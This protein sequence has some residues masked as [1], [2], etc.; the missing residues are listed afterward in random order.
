MTSTTPITTGTM[1]AASPHTTAAPALGP[2]RPVAWPKRTSV[3]LANGLEVVLAESHTFPKITAQ[4]FIRSGNA[5][6]AHRAPGVPD[7]TAR[8][9]RTGT[10][11]RTSRQIEED[12]RRMGADAGSSAG[13]DN[14][15]ISIG[16]LAEFSD[17]LFEL[18]A[19]LARNA[20]FP[21]DQ[22]ERERRQKIEGLRVERTTPGFLA[23]ERMRRVLFGD[24][25]YAVIAP[26]EE[27]VAAYRRDELEHFY[28][29]HYAPS[30]ALLLV[31]G[32]FSSEYN[33]RANRK[34]IWQLERLAA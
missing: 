5:A 23:N 27:Q 18:L 2:E 9:I 4:L 17:G 12:L 30:N 14:S 31:V 7:L 15:A 3:T 26:T 33:A 6:T 21:E 22:F 13:A 28:Q 32:D 19:D 29:R 20:S 24:H 34:S 25:R 16:G 10:A 8:V 1:P 11:T